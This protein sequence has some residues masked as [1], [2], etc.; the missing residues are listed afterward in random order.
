MANRWLKKE[1]VKQKQNQKKERNIVE[2]KG[3][4]QLRKEAR[5]ERRRSGKE[6]V[7]TVNITETSQFFLLH[8]L[9]LGNHRLKFG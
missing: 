3:N 5:K 4:G 6:R 1:K 9:Q 8:S 7:K 2:V